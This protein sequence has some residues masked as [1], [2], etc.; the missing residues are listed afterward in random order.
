LHVDAA[1]YSPESVN[2]PMMVSAVSSTRLTTSINVQRST[3]SE[4][5]YKD[6]MLDVLIFAMPVK[7]ITS[8]ASRYR[9]KNIATPHTSRYIAEWQTTRE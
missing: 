6:I 5:H 9:A 8:H 7:A 1:E 3:N 2:F 4:M